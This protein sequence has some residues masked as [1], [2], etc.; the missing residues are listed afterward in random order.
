M[1]MVFVPAGEFSMGSNDGESDE[2]PV[3]TVYLDAYYIDEYEVTN[4]QYRKC[5]EAG[6]CSQPSY[7]DDSGY[8]KP[9]QPVVGVNWNDAKTYCQWAGARLP[10]EAEWEKAAQGTDGRTYPWGNQSADCSRANYGGCVGRPAEVGQYPTGASPYGALDMA[11]NVWEWVADWYAADYY[12]RSPARNPQGPDSG[13]YRVLRGGSWSASAYSLRAAY[14]G[15][16]DPAD[17]SGSSG[18]RCAGSPGG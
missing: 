15:G 18:F 8:N 11:G 5:V 14:R 13:Q 17:R 1:V 12:G 10:T 7:W 2:K 3:H 4:A 9:N 6:V 16:S